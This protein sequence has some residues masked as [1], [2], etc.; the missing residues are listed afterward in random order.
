MKTEQFKIKINVKYLNKIEFNI[1]NLKDRKKEAVQS[2]YGK[3]APLT[4]T[5]DKIMAT[6]NNFEKYDSITF[7]KNGI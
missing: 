1:I 2:L 7:G 4:S 3:K 5:W 6:K